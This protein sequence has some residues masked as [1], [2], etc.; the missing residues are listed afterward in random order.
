[1][2]IRV[3]TAFAAHACALAHHQPADRRCRTIAAD[4]ARLQTERW[5]SQQ[6]QRSNCQLF[7]ISEQSLTSLK[8]KAFFVL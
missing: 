4:T 5:R 6:S 3:H 7:Q 8:S 2:S 1:M